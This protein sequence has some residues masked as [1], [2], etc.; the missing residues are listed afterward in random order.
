MNVIFFKMIANLFV[1]FLSPIKDTCSNI[2]NTGYYSP[3]KGFTIFAVTFQQR[4]FYNSKYLF[5]IGIYL[6]KNQ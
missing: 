2:L 5:Y 3:V 6:K 4:R 1:R